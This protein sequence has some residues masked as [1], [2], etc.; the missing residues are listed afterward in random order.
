MISFIVIGRNEAKHLS[1]CFKSIIA[2][3]ELNS[4]DRYEIIYVDSKSEDNC[5]E[6]AKSF[7]Q[8]KIY[9]LTADYNAA[10]ARNLGAEKS[11]GDVLF[12]VDGDMEIEEKFLI[13]NY[14][15][16][17]NCIITGNLLERFFND[18]DELTNEIIRKYKSPALGGIFIITKNLYNAL[19]GMDEKFR[20]SQDFEFALRALKANVTINVV[21]E[22]IAFHN[23]IPYKSNKRFFSDL[24]NWNY[25]YRALLLRKHFFNKNYIRI[26]LSENYSLLVLIITVIATFYL[27]HLFI[28]YLIV[29]IYRGNKKGKLSIVNPLLFIIRDIQIFLA[30]FTFFP[31]KPKSLFTK[32]Y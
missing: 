2:T 12:F 20:I 15:L 8:I 27:P 7:P 28:I 6:I 16:G 13:S 4:F 19:N 22:R 21:N 23:T 14:N 11:T 24:L 18:K 26:F 25:S 1:K 10:I 9:Q 29:I 3:V 5:I 30:F 17:L 31:Q 32:I